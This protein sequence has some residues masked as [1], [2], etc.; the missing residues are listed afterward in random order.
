LENRHLENRI[1][2]SALRLL[3][4][5]VVA[6]S[7]LLP[8]SAHGQPAASQPAKAADAA[9]D[10][11]S[12]EVAAKVEGMYL[13]GAALYRARKYRLAAQQFEAAYK[14]FPEPNLLY[15]AGRCYE[16]LGQIAKA[17]GSYQRFLDHPRADAATKTKA[18]AKLA[19]LKSAAVA[20][21]EAKDP[22]GGAKPAGTKPKAPPTRTPSKADE[23]PSKA[24]T[25]SKWI[26]GALGLAAAGVG[27]AMYMLGKKDHDE[28][29]DA[30]NAARGVAGI[31]SMTR[32]RAQELVDSGDTKK[33]LG[34]ILWSVG[35]A[36]LVASATFFLL[37]GGAEKP[38]AGDESDK[39]D[40]KADET[41]AISNIRVGAMPLPGGGSFSFSASF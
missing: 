17:M 21:T 32:A 34:V 39:G 31:I 41:A 12:P 22:Q 19:V 4:P 6:A 23:R 8:L 2:P 5:C 25:Y 3:A 30:K 10:K 9:P 36:A 16:A 37:D 1:M 7:L 40:A 28:V 38:Q 24:L 13:K 15:N 35:G 20:A 27:T 29:I 14:L 11:A 18:R 33:L 26:V